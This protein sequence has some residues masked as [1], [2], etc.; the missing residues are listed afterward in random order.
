[1]QI[2]LL[3]IPKI[4]APDGSIATVRGLQTWAVLAR[5]LLSPRP[6]SRRQLATELFPETV[7]PLGSLRW[8]L[9]SLR[10]SLGPEVL[11]GDPVLPNLA[12]SCRIDALS[13][14]D[15]DFDTLAAGE[16]LQDSAPE[17]CGAEFETW[18]LVERARLSARVDARLRRDTLAALAAGNADRALLLASHAVGRQRFDE[19]AHILLIRA[20]V[21]S[22]NPDA[23]LRHAKATEAD[24]RRELG[25]P[26]SEALRSAAR[27]RL[28]DPLPALAADSVTRSLL[29]AGTAALNVGAV[30]S[31]LESL[32]RAADRAETADDRNLLAEA[33][34]ELGTALIHSVRGQDDEGVVHLRRS[35]ELARLSQ[36]R[37][38]TCRAVLEQ[39]YA[40]AL[41][42]R[43]PDAADL[44]ERA[45]PLA[46]GDAALLATGHAFAGFN[47]ADWGRFS[48]ADQRFDRSIALARSA[49]AL[50]REIWALG[51]G[52]WGKLRSGNIAAAAD[53]AGESLALCNR[54]DWL[55]FRPWPETVLAE[56]ALL[57]GADPVQVRESLQQ[58]LALSCQLSDP[59]WEAATCRVIGLGLER[60]ADRRS[61]LL[62]LDRARS[63][64]ASVTDPYAALSLR[65]DFDRTRITLDENRSAGQVLLRALLVAAARLH[66]D[67]EL[68][69]ALALRSSAM[70]T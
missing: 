30:D 66:A 48:E 26:P 56:A 47:L 44:A 67:A 12:R 21:L 3:G 7:D 68:D 25:E 54:L 57:S 63:V 19:G 27:A 38:T 58:T 29:Q 59:C 60:E 1:M 14:D 69:A 4:I 33:L 20:L 41:A 13:V 52:A 70:A 45:L 32:R 22:G 42:G 39:C 61:A 2:R 11:T 43:R 46:D 37:P 34:A 65:T 10:R 64:L 17:A 62:W 24:F 8:C 55:S 9:A 18:L 16:L 6:L 35:E 40:E 28:A 49:G 5:V 23:A 31:G 53:W 15:P 51:I 50:R 36:N